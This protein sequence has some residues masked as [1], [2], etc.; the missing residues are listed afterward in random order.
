LFKEIGRLINQAVIIRVAIAVKK[1]SRRRRQKKRDASRNQSNN[2]GVSRKRLKPSTPG[3]TVRALRL[4][5]TSD[6]PSDRLR[7]VADFLR[8]LVHVPQAR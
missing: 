8:R 2:F 1:L 3:T 7:N 6:V 5:P 4:I